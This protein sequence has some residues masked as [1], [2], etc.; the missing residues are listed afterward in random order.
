MPHVLC[1]YRFGRPH[2]RAGNSCVRQLHAGFARPRGETRV[3]SSG[4]ERKRSTSA[5]VS[6][7]GLLPAERTGSLDSVE[8]V[9]SL[10]FGSFQPAAPASAPLDRLF[11]HKLDVAR[12]NEPRT[13]PGP[14]F[15]GA[16]ATHVLPITTCCRAFTSSG[17]DC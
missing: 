9:L 17:E 12:T 16:A 6:V 11:A 1:G 10:T 3:P 14:T 15:V 8:K 2:P 5:R 7:P 4:A 13:P